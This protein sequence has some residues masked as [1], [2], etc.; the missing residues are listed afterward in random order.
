MSRETS[1]SMN[2]NRMVETPD[3][4]RPPIKP[5]NAA[6]AMQ[7]LQRT[8]VSSSSSDSTSLSGS[9]SLSD[10]LS[11]TMLYEM[12]PNRALTTKPTKKRKREEVAQIKEEKGVV[13]GEESF[14]KKRQIH[15]ARKLKKDFKII[16]LNNNLK[17]MKHDGTLA[18]L[19]FNIDR[20]R[21]SN[22][23]DQ[24]IYARIKYHLGGVTAKFAAYRS[25]LRK[26]KSSLR[27][28]TTISNELL[29]K[30]SLSFNPDNRVQWANYFRSAH[31]FISKKVPFDLMVLPLPKPL[32][33]ELESD[34]K[35]SP[36]AY[37][38]YFN[39]GDNES[40]SLWHSIRRDNE[41][42]GVIHFRSHHSLKS[43]EFTKT[44]TADILKL[45]RNQSKIESDAKD[46]KMSD[47]HSLSSTSAEQDRSL[48]PSLALIP[49]PM[50]SFPSVQAGREQ[51]PLPSAATPQ[52][53]QDSLGKLTA[54][55]DEADLLLSMHQSPSKTQPISKKDSKSI[56]DYSPIAMDES[57]DSDDEK[58]TLIPMDELDGAGPVID[59]VKSESLDEKS[60][61]G[62]SIIN[63]NMEKSL[64]HWFNKLTDMDP[65]VRETYRM[66]FYKELQS[67]SDLAKAAAQFVAKVKNEEHNY[68]GSTFLMVAAQYHWAD[69]AAQLL[70]NGAHV[71]RPI[72][73]ISR[74][75]HGNTAP[76]IAA[77]YGS[78]DVLNE[79]I[80]HD[81]VGTI[82]AAS[83]EG[84]YHSSTPLMCAIDCAGTMGTLSPQISLTMQLL[85]NH[86]T[87]ADLNRAVTRKGPHKGWTAYTFAEHYQMK[88]IMSA[89]IKK[90]ATVISKESLKAAIKK[91]S[92]F[93][94]SYS[95]S[96]TSAMF[97]SA[98]ASGLGL[99][100]AS[101]ADSSSRF[102]SVSRSD[103]HTDSVQ[104]AGPRVQGS[105]L[106]S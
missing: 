24:V 3:D 89:L 102:D 14:L 6:A 33:D 5:E 85:I 57:K 15:H 78:T 4:L 19:E 36:G 80:K 32:I 44:S 23:S 18:E 98:S 77:M 35:E 17:A 74:A 100:A 86:S 97:V 104:M 101:S 34:L 71:N 96:Y 83:L 1:L 92:V 70:K 93:S 45:E 60:S 73:N 106:S 105:S 68:K 90:G 88:P 41:G 16:D 20:A 55:S 82:N 13:K 47:G 59:S 61:P 76:M 69:I 58:S 103:S 39:R 21:K 81:K 64:S 42:N 26:L 30:Y 9:L 84:E 72:V 66:K 79:M 27:F 91:E 67:N 31:K 8:I 28:G 94:M 87:A 10:R 62:D 48:T 43:I 2:D 37:D 7:L 75:D 51:K 22:I 29:H 63:V 95:S 65:F 46:V 11:S 49:F 12:F 53:A 54:T 38:R 40:P 56:D 99:K 50:L 52:G 25:G